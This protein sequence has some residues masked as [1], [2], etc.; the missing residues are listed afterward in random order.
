M[1]LRVTILA[2]QCAEEENGD[3]N[4]RTDQ[5]FSI[6]THAYSAEQPHSTPQRLRQ[7]ESQPAMQPTQ[8]EEYYDI[9]GE[10]PYDDFFQVTRI[11]LHE[12]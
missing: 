6:T 2:Y 12:H 7:S 5:S 4:A 3:S 1:M 8:E 9:E 11:L 10:N